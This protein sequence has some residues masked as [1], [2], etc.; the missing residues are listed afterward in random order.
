MGEPSKSGV[1]KLARA[2]RCKAWF[3]RPD[4][5]WDVPGKIHPDNKAE[6]RRIARER[7]RALQAQGEKTP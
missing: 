4:S 3:P 6:W 7:L 5:D 1:E 2:L